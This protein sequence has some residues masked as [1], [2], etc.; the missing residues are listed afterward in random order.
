[1]HFH[2]HVIFSLFNWCPCQCTIEGMLSP[3]RPLSCSNRPGTPLRPSAVSGHCCLDAPLVSTV[4]VLP[5]ISLTRPHYSLCSSFCHPLLTPPQPL[6]STA[7]LALSFNGACSAPCSSF[8]SVSSSIIWARFYSKHFSS[9]FSLLFPTT[10]PLLS[11]LFVFYGGA[12]GH[13]PP[14]TTSPLHEVSLMNCASHDCFLH[15]GCSGHAVWIFLFVSPYVCVHIFVCK[16]NRVHLWPPELKEHCD[17]WS[18]RCTLLD[19][20][21]ILESEPPCALIDWQSSLFYQI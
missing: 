4:A 18:V 12:F 10:G 19:S 11:L 1:M 8:F 20:Y 15:K 5:I 13:V 16:R 9:C 3:N 14:I 7:F 21:A 6:L 2:F 17:K